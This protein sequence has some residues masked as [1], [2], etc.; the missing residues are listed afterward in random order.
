MFHAFAF[1]D[2]SD[3]NL[4]QQLFKYFPYKYFKGVA[5]WPQLHNGMF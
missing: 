5:C 3:F 1:N 4:V 2:L